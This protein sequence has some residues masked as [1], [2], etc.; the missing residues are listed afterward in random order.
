MSFN[1]TEPLSRLRS[2]KRRRFPM[3]AV[4]AIAFLALGG[5]FY[6][7]WHSES[8]VAQAQN[9]AAQPALTVTVSHP[10]VRDLVEWDEY[11]GRFEAIDSVEIRA[12]VS[13]YLTEIAFEDGAR[14]EKGDL[15]FRVD[16]RP[17]DAAL[18][19]A[20]ADLASA[21]A[22]LAN[23][24]R[25][26]ERGEELVKTAALSREVLDRRKR[27]E[28]V[29]RAQVAAAQ[30]SLL[31]AQIN[32]DYTSIRAP[33]TGRVS[34]ERVSLGNLVTGDQTILT[35]LVSEDPIYFEFTISEAD[36]LDYARMM[37]ERGP[38]QVI[39]VQ[40]RLMDEDEFAHEG[41][42]S[43]VDNQLDRSTGTMRV[44]ATLDNPQGLLLPQMF[45][46]VRLAASE[47]RETLLITDSAIQS[48]QGSKYVWAVDANDVIVQKRVVLGPLM[49]DWRVV[50]AGVTS[51]DRIVTQGVQFVNSGMKVR[52]DLHQVDP[53][54]VQAF[55]APMPVDERG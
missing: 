16:P 48:D 3:I 1:P 25:D 45:G 21:K 36:Y 26:V 17:F 33:I 43:F 13:G 35:T 15:L 31:S 37:A 47:S 6:K 12:R 5:V 42:L 51:Q 14:V 46:R 54:I 18:D 9:G 19:R 7:G 23:A 32:L 29:A 28:D 39:P 52:P 44:R 20:K 11:T 34:D 53:Q 30:A 40:V 38:D 55:E 8:A 2:H 49:G 4:S 10:A 24:T 27:D 50:R 22:T 41:R